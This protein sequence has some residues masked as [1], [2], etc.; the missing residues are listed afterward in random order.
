[1]DVHL[2]THASSFTCMHLLVS[3]HSVGLVS[4]VVA[5][6]ALMFVHVVLL[7]YVASARARLA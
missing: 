1:M 2:C 7:A 5:H 6:L 3:L 4:A